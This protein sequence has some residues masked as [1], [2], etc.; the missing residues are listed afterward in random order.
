[1]PTSTDQGTDVPTHEGT[2]GGVPAY[3]V[4]VLRLQN[5]VWKQSKKFQDANPDYK[6]RK[7]LVYVGST[8]KTIDQRVDTHLKGGMQSNPYV[9]KYFRRKMERE[10]EDLPICYDRQSAEDLE[11]KTAEELRAR[12]WGVWVGKPSTAGIGEKERDA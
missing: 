8:G 5:Q 2:T 4:Y 3:R 11:E 6:P 7:P 10:H 1:M 12:G 9:R